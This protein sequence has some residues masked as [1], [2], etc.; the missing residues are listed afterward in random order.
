MR[1]RRIISAFLLSLLVI[2]CLFNVPETN[3]ASSVKDFATD[4][5]FKHYIWASESEN[6]IYF[7]TEAKDADEYSWRKEYDVKKYDISTGKVKSLYTVTGVVN[8]VDFYYINDK[9]YWVYSEPTMSNGGTDCTINVINLKTGKNTELFT[10]FLDGGS[11]RA[12]GADSSGRV[13]LSTYFSEKLI[14]FDKTG[15]IIA[16]SADDRVVEADCI[17]G[18]D[19]TNNNIYY[20][21]FYNWVYW[22][23]DHHMSSLCVARWNKNGTIELSEDDRCITIQYQSGFFTHHG[24][25]ELLNGRY[26]AD[27]STFSGDVFYLLDSREIAPSDVTESS[28]SISLLDSGVSVTG[29]NLG[30]KK[31]V[32]LGAQSKESE[33]V[34]NVDVSSVGSRAAYTRVDK[35]NILFLASDAT[36]VSC[37]DIDKKEF[38]GTISTKYSIYKVMVVGGK[39]VIVEKNDNK[40]FVE[41][42]EVKLPTQ[43]TLLGEKNLTVSDVTKY[44]SSF[45]SDI[46]LEVTYSSSNRAVVSVDKEGN[47]SAWRAGTAVITVQTNDGRIKDSFT[48][49][50]AERSTGKK[51]STFTEGSGVISNNEDLNSY[52]SYAGKV[53]SYISEPSSGILVRAE[54]QTDGTLLVENYNTSGKVTSSKTI[55]KELEG[56][57]GFFMGTSNNYVVFAQGNTDESDATEI[58]RVVKYD[59]NWGR[60]SACTIKG[61]NTRYP[62][63]SGSLRMAEANGVLYIHTCHTMYK[64]DDG[65]N[66]QANMTFAINES[67]MTVKDSYSDVMN[68]STGYVSHSF[69]QFI[70]IHDGHVWRADHGDAY[71]RGIAISKYPLGGS[72]AHPTAYGTMVGFE[73]GTGANYTG[74]SLGG[75]ELSITH[76]IVAYNRDEVMYETPRNIWTAAYNYETRESTTFQITKYTAST[77]INCSTPQLVKLNDS[78]FLL[79]WTEYSGEKASVAM[80]H[81]DNTGSPVDSVVKTDFTISDCQPIMLADKSV[82][83]YVTDGEKVS[84]YD[85]D[86]Y[87]TDSYYSGWKKES[88]KWTYYS[89]GDKSKNKWIEE[90]EKYYYVGADGYMQTGW[91]KINGKWYFFDGSGVM[92]TGWLSNG[93]KWYYMGEDGAMTRGWQK[94]DGKWYYLGWADDPDSGAMRTGWVYDGGTWYYM[95]SSGRMMTG[96]IQSGGTWYYL[97]GSGAMAANEYV[98]GYWLN[99]NGSWTY[100]HRASWRKSGNRWWYG[101]TSGWYA[102]NV[103]YKIDGVNYSFDAAGWMK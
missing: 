92:Q 60:V 23:Y 64:S 45:N 41:S 83:W 54:I 55:A 37:Y 85:I 21:G 101:D 47:A 46:S 94:V 59:S 61:E 2:T 31:A 44:A 8:G 80:V 19:E 39:L 48:V 67:D 62:V 73:G 96:W 11:P 28:T 75:L 16:Q 5:I 3:A 4:G 32:I 99:A 66:H 30:N 86:P 51:W 40:Y 14:V 26:L 24:C 25:A 6:S 87:K 90:G 100:P 68:L 78:Q 33:Y 88:N 74:A 95:H 79:M 36:T 50:V 102:A 7:V 71:P 56:A 57:V 72:M 18:I 29:V 91:Q 10:T 38:L 84:I 77:G 70:R 43:V 98:S 93:G 12:I 76:A 52:R 34:D 13:Y 42:F 35:K 17:F 58:L 65:L 27:L 22:G 20:N 15:K 69:N 81:L 97:K 82:A 53:T 89:W 1:S 9:L 49:N 63:S 103:T